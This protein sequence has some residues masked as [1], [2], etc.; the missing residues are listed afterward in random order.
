VPDLAGKTDDEARRLLQELGL[1]AAQDTPRSDPIVPEGLVL[2]QQVPA[3]SLVS[4]GQPVTYTLSRGP[5]LVTIPNVVQTRQSIARQQ[6]EALGLL[7]DVIEQGSATVTADF[8][9]S[10]VPSANARLQPGETVQLIVS[11]G[12]K[13][14]VPRLVGILER[15]AIARI[16]ATDGLIYSYSDYQGRDKLGDQFDQVAPLTVVSCDPGEGTWVPRGTGI[17]LGVRAAN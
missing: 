6:L 5:D 7:V 16:Q 14:F 8:V 13:V 10:Q 1:L 15:D 11:V 17:T 4:Q 12:D 3:G 9:I 2:D